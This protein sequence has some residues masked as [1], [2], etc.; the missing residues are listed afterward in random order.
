LVNQRCRLETAILS[1]GREDPGGVQA[2]DVRRSDL[3]EPHESLAVV[4]A[5]VGEPEELSEAAFSRSE[6]VIVW[7]VAG[8][9]ANDA[10]TRII[11]K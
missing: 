1:A 9:R 2:M 10:I 7:A 4:V 5:S 11:L 3:I 8:E 6:A